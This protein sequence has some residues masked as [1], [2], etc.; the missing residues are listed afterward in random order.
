MNCRDLTDVRHLIVDE[1]QDLV[2]VRA[3][4]VLAVLA[5][6]PPDVGFT[7][8]GDPHQAVYDFQLEDQ[9]DMTSK[10]FL[11]RA[12]QLGV[13][14]EVR[15]TGSTARVLARHAP[16]LTPWGTW[17]RWERTGSG[18]CGRSCPTSSW[19][20]TSPSWPDQCRGGRALRRFSAGPTARP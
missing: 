10:Q 3:R 7:L 11:D 9:H 17:R 6:L 4:L 18:R 12:R 16:Q 2:G 20:V 5:T 13:V 1:V 15:L 8:L 14:K 19:R